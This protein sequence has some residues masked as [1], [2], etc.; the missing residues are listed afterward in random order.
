MLYSGVLATLPRARHNQ[1]NIN[2]QRV[3]SFG[4]VAVHIDSHCA[5][6]CGTCSKITPNSSIRRSDRL[7]GTPDD[8]TGAGYL[9]DIRLHV[10]S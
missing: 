3:F 5:N 10:A 2:Q 4:S 6:I 9:A 1:S 8:A 7:P